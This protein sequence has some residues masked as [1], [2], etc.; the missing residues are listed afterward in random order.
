MPQ[1]VDL[2]IKV[3]SARGL[4][5]AAPDLFNETIVEPYC[6]CEIMGR[7]DPGAPSFRTKSLINEDRPQ[8]NETSRMLIEQ[9]ESLIFMVNYKDD[10]SEDDLIGW[11]KLEYSAMMPNGFVGEL[12]LSDAAASQVLPAFL[13]VSVKPMA[14]A[15]PEELQAMFTPVTTDVLSASEAPPLAPMSSHFVT[16]SEELAVL[17]DTTGEMPRSEL[18]NTNVN[19]EVTSPIEVGELPHPLEFQE[20]QGLPGQ[21]ERMEDTEVEH[22]EVEHALT[23]E[24]PGGPSGNESSPQRDGSPKSAS[25]SPEF[26]MAPKLDQGAEHVVAD[27]ESP[28]RRKPKASSKKRVGG[29]GKPPP[30]PKVPEPPPLVPKKALNEHEE[31]VVSA[32]DL[33]CRQKKPLRQSLEEA[34]EVRQTLADADADE[35][36][37]LS[38]FGLEA[39][40]GPRSFGQVLAQAWTGNAGRSPSPAAHMLPWPSN[41]VSHR[42][43]PGL[44]SCSRSSAAQIRGLLL[45]LERAVALDPDISAADLLQQQDMIIEAGKPEV[46]LEAS[47]LGKF[48]PPLMVAGNVEP[49]PLTL[50]AISSDEEESPKKDWPFRQSVKEN[51][52]K[53][54]G[55]TVRVAGQ[56]KS[57]DAG[58]GSHPELRILALQ[59][60]LEDAHGSLSSAFGAMDLESRGYVSFGD[61]H[62]HLVRL[63]LSSVDAEGSS[64]AMEL[65]KLLDSDGD[66]LLSPRDCLKAFKGAAM[67]VK[68]RADNAVHQ[69]RLKGFLREQGLP[70]DMRIPRHKPLGGDEYSRA[71]SLQRYLIL[72]Y[73]SL[74]EA[75]HSMDSS[76][77]G[78]VSNQD[79]VQRLLSDRYCLSEFEAE[80]LFRTFDPWGKGWLPLQRMLEYEV[81]GM[82]WLR[83]WVNAASPRSVSPRGSPRGSPRSA[84][85]RSASP[86]SASPRSPSPRNAS[87]RISP[88]STTRRSR[89]NSPDRFFTSNGRGS[90]EE[91][92]DRSDFLFSDP[93]RLD[94]PPPSSPRRQPSP[95]RSASPRSASPAHERLYIAG[96]GHKRVLPGDD[97]IRSAY[98]NLE[99]A[100]NLMNDMKKKAKERAATAMKA[101]DEARDRAQAAKAA[102]E[103]GAVPPSL[104]GPGPVERFRASRPDAQAVPTI[105]LEMAKEDESLGALTPP[106]TPREAEEV[107]HKESRI[108]AVKAMASA[109]SA[110]SA[111]SGESRSALQQRRKAREQ[112][113]KEIMKIMDAD[114]DGVITT[115]ELNQLKAKNPELS[116]VDMSKL[117]VD[118]DGQISKEELEQ[119]LDFDGEPKTQAEEA[120]NLFSAMANLF[121]GRSSQAEGSTEPKEPEKKEAEVKDKDA[122]PTP[123]AK[124]LPKAL[125]AMTRVTFVAGRKGSLAVSSTEDPQGST[126][127]ATSGARKRRDLRKAGKQAALLAVPGRKEEDAG[128]G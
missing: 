15:E 92:E 56:A 91:L 57:A 63:H 87:P 121:G 43:V 12:S 60:K 49:M 77:I 6:L 17:P 8:W 25:P 69:E 97:A 127:Q 50:T 108:S 106:A 31:E 53:V 3:L 120:A 5:D 37:K 89:A 29:A 1:E 90:P 20:P 54:K 96:I 2:L 44:R 62:S 107:A 71:M 80:A 7:D 110:V 116:E 84:S 65:F 58:F 103:T 125:F 124:A 16:D 105:Y 93:G 48:P 34:L 72:K 68:E 23:H 102:A 52:S 14:L 83:P 66:D 26:E 27:K 41:E 64:R 126:T 79:F 67:L 10:D 13:K 73:G 111:Q 51:R 38:S 112:R 94:G 24:T 30:P 82:E 122:S 98:H 95:R 42:E 100:K 47:G 32:I 4:R 18:E 75:V 101:V 99:E 45:H 61:F 114:G 22:A 76:G 104:Q 115:N 39:D 81:S 123:K 118:G 119:A 11:A 128:D 46:N 9:G 19:L 36:G 70:L 35:E 59:G 28:T 117:D 85:P 55:C 21:V 86:R 88:W 78:F 40:K 113:R 33:L 74:Y 109:A